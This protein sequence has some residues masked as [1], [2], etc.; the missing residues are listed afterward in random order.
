MLIVNEVKMKN[1]RR[2]MVTQEK[3]EEEVLTETGILKKQHSEE[4]NEEIAN[5]LF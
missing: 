2:M 1:R 4:I 5:M 3:K